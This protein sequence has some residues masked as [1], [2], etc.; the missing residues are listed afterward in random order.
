[1]VRPIEPQSK[2][3]WILFGPSNDDEHELFR[4][5]KEI[6]RRDGLTY[7][8]KFLPTIQATVAADNPQLK[9]V[10]AG[11]NLVLNKTVAKPETFPPRKVVC[12][13]CKGAGCPDCSGYGTV[14][15][16]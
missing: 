16:E 12:E 15:V 9:F 2:R 8:D 6:M 13:H 14:I 10:Q 1:M 7:R 4:K 11:D 3:M 5:F